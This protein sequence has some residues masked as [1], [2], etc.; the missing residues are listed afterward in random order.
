MY[1]TVGGKDA[2]SSTPFF[3]ETTKTFDC[4]V[5]SVRF[6]RVNF[7]PTRKTTLRG[8]TVFEAPDI[9]HLN[10]IDV[11]YVEGLRSF[12]NGAVFDSFHPVATFLARARFT[13]LYEVLNIDRLPGPPKILKFFGGSK[14]SK[15]CDR[16]C[17]AE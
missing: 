6:D 8:H 15:M 16:V 5:S 1:A 12:F 17:L 11:N 2:R 7:Q 3:D 4:V 13:R 10:K 14:H 9:F